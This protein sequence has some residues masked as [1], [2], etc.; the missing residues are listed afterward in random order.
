[1]TAAHKIIPKSNNIRVLIVDDSAVVRGLTSRWLAAAADLEL[2]GSACDGEDGIR[3][4]TDLQPD[5]IILDVEMPKLDGLSALPKILAAAPKAKVVMASTLTSRNADITLKALSAGAADY[6]PKPD[7]GRLAGAAE[8]QRDLVMKVRALGGARLSGAVKTSAADRAALSRKPVNQS[9]APFSAVKPKALAI[10]SS[11]G[12]P[13]ALQVVVKAIGKL[14]APVFITQHMPATFTT[15][16]AA[17]LDKISPATVMEGKDGLPVRPGHI[18]IAPGEYHMVMTK[19]AGA[20]VI[21]LNQRPPENFCRPAVDPML[22]AAAETYGQDLLAVVLTGMGH[23]GAAGA[24]LVIKNK[25][26]VIA[27]DE[28]TSVVWGMPGAVASAGAACAI[29][30]L[31]QIGKSVVDLFNGKRR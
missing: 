25:G 15:I 13:Q 4:A 8:Y 12:G 27:Q 29:E 28:A 2:V 26:S 5:V 3:K 23:D 22:R 10:G 7:T 17:H 21:Q 24:Q 30:P 9:F 18:Y 16:L 6:L 11:T 20:V 1:M 31:E 19:R 14:D